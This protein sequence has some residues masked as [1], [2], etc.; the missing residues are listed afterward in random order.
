MIAHIDAVDNSKA[1][2]FKYIKLIGKKLA[3]KKGLFPV[4][5]YSFFATLWDFFSRNTSSG[6]GDSIDL[7]MSFNRHGRN[8]KTLN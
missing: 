4:L 2:T 7:S 3:K 6:S 8:N 1:V 5:Y